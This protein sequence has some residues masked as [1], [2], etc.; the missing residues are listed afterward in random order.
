MY[1]YPESR[2]LRKTAKKS[3]RKKT[4]WIIHC[5]EITINYYPEARK[6]RQIKTTSW[7]KC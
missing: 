3:L 1:L 5:Q 2:I 4:V 6:C 7:K